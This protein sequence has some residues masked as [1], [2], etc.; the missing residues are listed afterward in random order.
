MSGDLSGGALLDDRLIKS[1]YGL[2]TECDPEPRE[3]AHHLWN[4]RRGEPTSASAVITAN[5]LHSFFR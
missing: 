3:R 5:L 2:R 4:C 1:K